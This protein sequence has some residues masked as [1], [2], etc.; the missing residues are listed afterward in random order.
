MGLLTI[1]TIRVLLCNALLSWCLQ[2]SERRFINA[3][4]NWLVWNKYKFT[5]EIEHLNMNIDT[6][7]TWAYPE[8][9]SER[10]ILYDLYKI[11]YSWP[12]NGTLAGHWN[13]KEGTFFNLTQYKYSRRQD[14]RGIVYT[15]ALVVSRPVLHPLNFCQH[16]SCRSCMSVYEH[17]FP[18]NQEVRVV[19]NHY[20]F[21][22]EV[23]RFSP[24][25]D[26]ECDD[27][28]CIA[29]FKVSLLTTDDSLKQ[30]TACSRSEFLPAPLLRI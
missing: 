24:G 30:A 10:I 4:F 25:Q 20:T 26:T 19:V 3:T 28:F 7:M 2:N 13:L 23:P 12:I 15:A 18:L 5:S 1:P 14:L 11:N 8:T 16:F 29:F 22:C 6:E 21:V 17:Y 9:S 27:R